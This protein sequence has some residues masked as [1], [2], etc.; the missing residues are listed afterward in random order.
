[1]SAPIG[2]SFDGHSLFMDLTNLSA[3]ERAATVDAGG[4]TAMM[5]GTGQELPKRSPDE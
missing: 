1:M 2:V 4:R 3:Q 5:M